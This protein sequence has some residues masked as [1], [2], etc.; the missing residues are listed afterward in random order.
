MSDAGYDEDDDF[1]DDDDDDYPYNAGEFQ[2][3][4]LQIRSLSSAVFLSGQHTYSKSSS[5]E[6]D[7]H[8]LVA[9]VRALATLLTR[10]S[11]ERVVAVTGSPSDCSSQTTPHDSFIALMPMPPQYSAHPGDPGVWNILS[12]IDIVPR[13]DNITPSLSRQVP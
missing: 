6:P 1:E 3:L 2:A 5:L 13:S 4:A 11:C 9:I 8:P 10:N 7:R 12:H